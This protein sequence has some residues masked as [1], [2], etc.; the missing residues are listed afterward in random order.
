MPLPVAHGLLGASIVAAV[1]PQ[2]TKRYFLP[3]FVGGFLAN[4]PDADFL[5]VFIFQ[6]RTW[7]RGFSHSILFAL[8]VC[9]VFVLWWGKQYFRQA[10]AYGL[11]LASHGILDYLTTK[12]GRGVELLWPFSSAKLGLHWVGLSEMPSRLPAPDIMKAL[13]VEFVLFAPLLA[14]IICSRTFIW[15]KASAN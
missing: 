4:V 13:A 12:R 3:L 10:A 8:V 1:H 14:L 6:S 11:A 9:L 5:L 7:H 2:P 15:K